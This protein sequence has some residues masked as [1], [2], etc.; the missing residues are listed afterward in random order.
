MVYCGIFVVK[1]KKLIRK[2][3]DWEF[4]CFNRKSYNFILLVILR[5]G[6][7]LVFNRFMKCEIVCIIN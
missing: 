4:I 7:L 2:K 5:K 1:I 6:F 3:I